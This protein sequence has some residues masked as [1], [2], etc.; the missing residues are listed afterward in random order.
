[1]FQCNAQPFWPR[2]YFEQ[3]GEVWELLDLRGQ[4]GKLGAEVLTVGGGCHP[5]R[6]PA[7]PRLRRPQ[8]LA[9]TDEA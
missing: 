6:L 1:M 5:L 2:G 9:L 7:A 8:H 3:A 4:D